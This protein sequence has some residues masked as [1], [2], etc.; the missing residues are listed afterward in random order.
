MSEAKPQEP[1]TLKQVQRAHVLQVL[2]EQNGN[3][4]HAARAL[5]VDRRTLYRWLAR[6][7]AKS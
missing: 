5:G 7:A 2:A 6:M 4:T 3:K 1:K